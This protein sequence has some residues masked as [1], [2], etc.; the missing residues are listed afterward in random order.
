[1]L[2]MAGESAMVITNYVISDDVQLQL[3]AQCAATEPLG[4]ILSATPFALS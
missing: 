3:E 2:G 1:M 4:F